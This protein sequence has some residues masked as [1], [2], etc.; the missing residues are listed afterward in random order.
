VAREAAGKGADARQTIGSLNTA[1]ERISLVVRLIADIASQTNL[2]ALN[3]TIEAARAGEAGK[4]FAVVAGEVKALATET[5]R[6]TSEIT[7]QIDELRAATIAAVSQ[8]EAIGQTLDMVAEVSISLAAA[9]E[10][11]T[12]A[13]QEIARNVAESGDAMKLI[14]KLMDAISKEAIITGDKVGRLRDSA[15]A[16]AEDVVALRTTLVRMVRTATMDADR[17]MERRIMVDVQCA[18]T[19]DIDGTST[20]GTIRD[21]SAHGA[22]IDIGAGKTH[23]ADERGGLVLPHA[24]NARAQ[25]KVRSL[26][27]SGELRVQFVEGKIEPRFAAEVT[28]LVASGKPPA[29][30]A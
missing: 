15:G 22:L 17:R 26:G 30:A 13:T 25:F 14:T 12:G 9:I 20:P 29:M 6:A 24:G 1:G 4:G 16:V 21:L 23:F 18:V 7:R 11:Q 2:L 8:V 10:Q 27:G 28:R 19:F 3:A 5:A